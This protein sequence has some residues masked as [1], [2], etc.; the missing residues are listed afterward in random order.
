MSTTDTEQAIADRGGLELHF[1]DRGK[2]TPVVLLHALTANADANWVQT[3]VLD[4]LVTAGFRVVAPDLRGHGDSP[5]AEQDAYSLELIVEDVV[6]LI[7]RLGLGAC[8]L[9]GYSLGALVAA[10]IAAD[11]SVPLLRVV[12][13]GV[14]AETV[15]KTPRM[16]E[17]DA[18]VEAMLAPDAEAISDPSLKAAR[19]RVEAWR[20]DPTAVA[21]I[22]RALQNESGA[23]LAAIDLPVLVLN[24]IDDAPTAQVADQID[25]ARSAT[26]AGDHITAPLDPT[27][28]DRI[29]E[30]LSEEDRVT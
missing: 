17:I 25:G 8:H 16:P 26:V 2:G 23:D 12:L 22:Y 6:T 13:S 18:G 29:V 24:G 19:L 11:A 27:F 5:R 21:A 15:G 14:G 3:G 9:V 10:R 20:T 1:L 28:P 4:K 30:F 7:Q